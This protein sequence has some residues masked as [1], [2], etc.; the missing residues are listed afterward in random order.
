MMLVIAVNLIADWL[1][2]S[3]VPHIDIKP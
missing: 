2:V 1:L 3:Y